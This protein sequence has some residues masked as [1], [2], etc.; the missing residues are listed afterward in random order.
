MI[1]WI[2]SFGSRGVGLFGN[3]IQ[4]RFWPGTRNG[5]LIE[6]YTLNVSLWRLQ[7]FITSYPARLSLIAILVILLIVL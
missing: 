4:V 6:R 2:D 7:L 3:R 1:T 5:L